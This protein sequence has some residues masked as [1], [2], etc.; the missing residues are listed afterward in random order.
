VDPKAIT[1]S[2]VPQV[3]I[4]TWRA[5]SKNDTAF[6]PEALLGDFVTSREPELFRMDLPE[7]HHQATLVMTDR[8][9][10]ATD[11]GPLNVVVVE[12]FGERP[13]L[14]DTVVKKGDTLV[15]RFNFNM[16]GDRFSTFRIRFTPASG[17][18]F[19]VN[20]LTI[21]RIEPHIAHRPVLRAAPGKDLRLVA[22]VTLPPPVPRPV[23]NSLSIARGTLSTLDAPERLKQ[24]TVRYA[25]GA[26]GPFQSLQM[27]EV[28]PWTYAATVPAQA[29]TA[30]TLRY[31]IEAVDSIGQV[32]ASPGRAAASPWHDVDVTEDDA[33]PAVTHTAVTAHDPGRPLEIRTRVTDPSGVEE[34]RLHYRPTRHKQEFVTVPMRPSGDEYVAVVP[35]EF[36][37]DRFD[38]M[39]YFEVLDTHRN[40]AIVPDPEIEQ[41]Y[42]VVK[43]SRA[44]RRGT[45]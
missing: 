16:V 24:V 10:E 1:A 30:G 40:G 38:L 8:R 3:P 42:Y 44:G 9:A 12:R 7:G 33:P 23:M 5:A 29:V 15:T 20:A 18:D 41:P 27:T 31:V 36:I 4:N 17:A 14:T 28:A 39:Y 25:T 43:I 11:H 13:I 34:V 19:I 21:T 35:G 22:T 26:A 37:T 2:L 6:P 32:V 45:R